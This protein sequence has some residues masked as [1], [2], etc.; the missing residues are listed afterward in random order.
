MRIIVVTTLLLVCGCCVWSD[1]NIYEVQGSNV[2]L[3]CPLKATETYKVIWKGPY[4]NNTVYSQSCSINSNLPDALSSRIFITG[5]H[6]AGE[7]DLRIVKVEISDAGLYECSVND[8]KTTINL[9]FPALLNSTEATYNRFLLVDSDLHKLFVG[10]MNNVSIIDLSEGAVKTDN[11]ELLP[12]TDKLNYCTLS[13]PTVPDCQ[14]HIRFITKKTKDK[15]MLFGSNADSPKG[16]ELNMTD[17]TQSSSVVPCSNDP[18]HNFTVLYVQSQN[19]NDEELMYYAST[20]HGESTIQR[21]I[22]GSTDYMKG[23]ISEKWMKDPQFVA[24]FD[25]EDKVYFFFR[26]TAVEVDP[27]ETKIY[28][29]VAKVCK[30][31][32]GGN[33]LLRNKWTSFQK[34]RLTCNEKHVHY[35]SI[36]DVV[37]KDSTFYGLFI[38]KQGTPASAICAF[39]LTSIEAAINGPFKDQATDNSYWAEATNVPT[40]RPGQCTEDSLSL[41]EEGLQFIADHP[42]MNNTVEQVN[43]K[44][45][46]LLDDRELQ[47]LELHSNMSEI[48]LY[49]ASNNGEVYK[50]FFKDGSTY[51]DSMYSPLSNAEVIWALKQYNDSVYIGTDTSVKRI[52]VINCEQYRW[53]DTCVKDPHCA[54][55]NSSDYLTDNIDK[56]DIQCYNRCKSVEAVMQDLEIKKDDV[57]TYQNY[58]LTKV[59]LLTCPPNKPNYMSVVFTSKSSLTFQWTPRSSGDE[60]YDYQTFVIQYRICKSEIWRS[61]K[62][63]MTGAKNDPQTASISQLTEGSLYDI[64]MI[65]NNTIGRSSYTDIIVVSTLS[66]NDGAAAGKTNDEVWKIVLPAVIAVVSSVINVILGFMVWTRYVNRNWFNNTV[67]S[68]SGGTNSLDKNQKTN[69]YI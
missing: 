35:D 38:T 63:D 65:A 61:T 43:G 50:L 64:R 14:N 15:L 60:V 24:S 22:P 19:P 51:I 69:K 18:F 36:Q 52:Q 11:I 31:D 26:E 1:I 28:S 16:F 3:K 2:L 20:L 5:N 25:I 40:P 58:D 59:T 62:F 44:P 53:I 45:V 33:S 49:T 41:S 21:P 67:N 10:Q 39:N 37:M 6:S 32:V 34:A 4:K 12:E 68:S 47:H 66:E 8:L 42:L 55:V 29:R 56:D 23:V 7:Y 57:F 46:F 48:V 54:W 13:K 17:M 30:K 9:N 27:A